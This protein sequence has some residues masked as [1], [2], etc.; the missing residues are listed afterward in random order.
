MKDIISIQEPFSIGDTGQSIDT[1]IETQIKGLIDQTNNSIEYPYASL[2][3]SRQL[4]FSKTLD[5]STVISGFMVNSSV[6][7][8]QWV[9]DG[10]H[11]YSMII[12]GNTVSLYRQKMLTGGASV[13]SYSFDAGTDISSKLEFYYKY[14]RIWI[15][16]QN[17]TTIYFKILSK[18]L[19]VI[20]DGVLKARAN[21][22]IDLLDIGRGIIDVGEC[23]IWVAV[24]NASRGWFDYCLYDFGGNFIK[25]VRETTISTTTQ[26]DYVNVMCFSDS[27]VG[28]YES[29]RNYLYDKDGNYLS[30]SYYFNSVMLI[31]TN[32][33]QRYG[34]IMSRLTTNGIY[35][36][37]SSGSMGGTTAYAYGRY[38]VYKAF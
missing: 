29:D 14:N 22:S 3:S 35:E 12:S 8:G 28:V 26:T 18:D 24:K 7:V 16:W 33:F 1:N 5:F 23:G 38:G 27:K 21:M 15:F 31:P 6:A 37:S 9:Y 2:D 17:G 10:L 25:V 30:R 34:F 32:Y 20:Y 4:L 19:I 36:Y 13:N 11:V